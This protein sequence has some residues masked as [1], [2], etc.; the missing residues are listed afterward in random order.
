MCVYV[1]WVVNDMV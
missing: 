1:D